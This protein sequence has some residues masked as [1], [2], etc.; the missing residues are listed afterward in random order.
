MCSKTEGV[1]M[2]YP[3]VLHYKPP[4]LNRTSTRGNNNAK[5]EKAAKI[6]K[7]AKSIGQS[8]T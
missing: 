3:N 5:N 8:E 7:A 6:W 4:N 2:T 1:K